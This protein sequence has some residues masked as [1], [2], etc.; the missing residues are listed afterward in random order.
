M[1]GWLWSMIIF[2]IILNLGVGVMSLAI[3]AFDLDP[4]T[5]DPTLARG[6]LY[7]ANY[8]NSLTDELNETIDPIGGTAEDEDTVFR[9]VL[10]F[11][12]V[13]LIGNMMDAM[14]RYL[15]GFVLI[16]RILFG[17][18]MSVALGDMVFGGLK[19]LL[20]I[21]YLM[22]GYELWQIIRGTAE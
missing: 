16:L 2:S 1:K 17:G 3:P 22:F 21:G 4:S 20:F 11:L 6:M 12:R 15:F 14:D 18:Y 5:G 7:H 19:S 13:G 9:G 8:A 10:D